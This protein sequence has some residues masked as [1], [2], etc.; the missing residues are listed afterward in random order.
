MALIYKIKGGWNSA[1]LLPVGPQSASEEDT[2]RPC[3]NPSLLAGIIGQ[4]AGV[5]LVELVGGR[6]V[7]WSFTQLPEDFALPHLIPA[8]V[9][10]GSSCLALKLH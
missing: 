1:Y 4:R 6:E 9:L 7:N 3:R 2:I 8:L 5:V 10:H